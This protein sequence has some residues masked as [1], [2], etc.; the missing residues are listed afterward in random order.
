MIACLVGLLGIAIVAVPAGII[1]AG[2]TEAIEEDK[3]ATEVR[4]DAGKLRKVFERKLDRLSGYQIV[5][6]FRSDADAKVVLNMKND[7]LNEAVNYGPGFRL[8][9]LASTVPM[10]RHVPDRV[11]IEHFPVNK[12]YGCMIDR[13]SKITVISPSSM[14][15]ACVGNFAFY[16]ALIGGF[17][18][19]SREKGSALPISRSMPSPA[20]VTRWK[21]SGSISTMW[22]RCSTVRAGGE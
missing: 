1:G 12:P 20:T 4:E 2:F 17:N 11:A 8:I 18:Y 6:P 5:P 14:V 9:N 7:N 15:D 3:K 10:T 13:G 19:I 22:R 21:G 16:L